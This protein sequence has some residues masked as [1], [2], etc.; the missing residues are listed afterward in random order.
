MSEIKTKAPSGDPRTR[1][2]YERL[3]TIVNNRVTASAVGGNVS[4]EDEWRQL[5]ATAAKSRDA[6]MQLASLP[7]DDSGGSGTLQVNLEELSKAAGSIDN[8]RDSAN[9]TDN[10]AQKN[11]TTAAGSL[12]GWQSSKALTDL[13]G[14][15]AKQATALSTTLQSISQGLRDSALYIGGTE[16]AVTHGFKK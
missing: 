14:R 13:D 1:L 9:E 10:T 15:W 12:S 8:I 11:T 7:G 6:K 5:Q 4:F 3:L 16:S 2:P